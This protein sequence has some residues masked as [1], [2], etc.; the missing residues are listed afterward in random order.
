MLQLNFRA[1]FEIVNTVHQGNYREV[2]IEAD[3]LSYCSHSQ[4]EAVSSGCFYYVVLVTFL[5]QAP[6][7]AQGLPTI[8]TVKIN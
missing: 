5:H 7:V 8:N 4:I 6:A 3:Q 2:T 1:R